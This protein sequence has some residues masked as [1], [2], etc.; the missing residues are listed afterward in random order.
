[1]SRYWL[2]RWLGD[3]EMALGGTFFAPLAA[4]RSENPISAKRQAENDSFL[5]QLGRLAVVNAGPAFR[6]QQGDQ[7]ECRS[8]TGCFQVGNVNV[9]PLRPER[10]GAVF[11]LPGQQFF[12]DIPDITF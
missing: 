7:G 1:M 8:I 5:R 4:P 9:P 3:T 12:V 10:P 2:L 6:Q 11:F